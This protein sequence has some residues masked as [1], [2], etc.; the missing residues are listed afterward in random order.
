MMIGNLLGS[1]F[2]LECSRLAFA[3]SRRAATSRLDAE[4]LL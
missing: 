4:D 1:V 2:Y 3:R